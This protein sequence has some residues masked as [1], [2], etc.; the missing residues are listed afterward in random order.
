MFRHYVFSEVTQ[1]RWY[2]TDIV[3]FLH[4][5][6]D[7]YSD[8]WNFVKFYDCYQGVVKCETTRLSNPP[9]DRLKFYCSNQLEE[10]FEKFD[11]WLYNAPVLYGQWMCH[12]LLL[13]LMRDLEN[14]TPSY[15]FNVWTL[16][17]SFLGHTQGCHASS[18][19]L[20]SPQF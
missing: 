12:A 17:L 20:K 1:L 2:I 6:I 8:I 18:N 11:T 7:F 4:K 15:I 16:V 9:S 10:Q 14:F 19:L 13:T 5:K 3:R